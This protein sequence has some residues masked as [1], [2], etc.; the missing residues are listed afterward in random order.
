M[1]RCAFRNGTECWAGHGT[2]PLSFKEGALW[3]PSFAPYQPEDVRLSSMQKQAK[4]QDVA[5][6]GRAIYESGGVEITRDD[7]WEVDAL[8]MSGQVADRFPVVDG[9]PYEV[10]LARRSWTHAPNYGGWVQ[11]YFC[12]CFVPGTLVTM[13]GQFSKPIEEVREGDLVM[14][15]D[16]N[17][18]PS[19]RPVI[20]TMCRRHGEMIRSISVEGADSQVMCTLNHP[21]MADTGD[22]MKWTPAGDLKVGS[23]VMMLG[24]YRFEPVMISRIT[25]SKYDGYVYN[26]DVA[27]DHDYVADGFLVHNCTWG[28]Y[29]SGRP[30]GDRWG[31]R[32]C[33][34]AYST[35]LAAD[36]RAR[37]DFMNDRTAGLLG[38]CKACGDYASLNPMNGLCPDCE[39][40]KTFDA[41]VAAVFIGDE[42]AERWLE[43]EGDPKVMDAIDSEMTLDDVEG[44]TKVAHWH[45]HRA[46]VTPR[47][48]SG[49]K[50]ATRQF[51]YAEMKE[52]DEEIDGK[53]LHN[54]S[55]LKAITEDL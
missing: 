26:L 40:G 50:D 22:G 41:F 47:R 7:S 36:A 11:A 51:T 1:N 46:L 55:R 20:G 6:K 8:V 52:L 42:D 30:G 16:V 29:H 4:W 19:V 49:I 31:G 18:R 23:V 21:W 33:S 32:L 53:P 27:E 17:G 14:T 43:S 48:T 15:A 38:T 2:C 13:A 35:L 44:G 3:C 12:E 9:G 28:Q 34:H 25:D 10:T 45:G 24:D 39:D 5:D 54:R 37:G